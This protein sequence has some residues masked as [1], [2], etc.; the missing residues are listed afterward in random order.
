MRM[1]QAAVD[2]S[3]KLLRP[4]IRGHPATYVLELKT[5]P[6]APVFVHCE[7]VTLQE[8]DQD[9]D[10][11][12][13]QQNGTPAGKAKAKGPAAGGKH[14]QPSFG[15]HH[16]QLRI[17]PFIVEFTPQNWDRPREVHCRGTAMSR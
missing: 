14:K 13:G 3:A 8:L 5:A 7:E 17:D 12:D 11:A 15:H 9:D 1:S 4:V 16:S 10:D 6:L 2:A